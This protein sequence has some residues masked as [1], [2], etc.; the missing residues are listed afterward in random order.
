MEYVRTQT[1]ASPFR[2]TTGKVGFS[3]LQLDRAQNCYKENNNLVSA[4]TDIAKTVTWN[5]C[6]ASYFRTEF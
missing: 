1:G 2:N 5:S 3:C 4:V 6:S